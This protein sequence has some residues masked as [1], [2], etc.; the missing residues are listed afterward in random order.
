MSPLRSMVWK[1]VLAFVLVS[2]AT[3]LYGNRVEVDD[4]D[5]DERRSPD[6]NTDLPGRPQKNEKWLRI[7]CTL[8]VD[9]GRDKFVDEIVLDWYILAG[10]RGP[11][12]LLHREVTYTDVEEGDRHGCIFIPP[13][14]FR[15]YM[16]TED[17]DK[18]NFRVL[19]RVKV[20]GEYQAG[21]FYPKGK[22]RR[23]WWTD[24]DNRKVDGYLLARPETPFAP[25]DWWYYMYIKPGSLRN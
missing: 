20:N 11:D 24:S 12:I 13:T 1:A 17:P 5:F 25:L 22:P 9:G 18:D 19:V 15:R 7:T 2:S 21:E 23:S 6:Y 4:I 10:V 14:F 16:D 3:A 8:D